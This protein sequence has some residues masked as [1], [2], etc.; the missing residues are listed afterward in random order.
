ML[1]EALIKSTCE[2]LRRKGELTRI[3]KEKRTADEIAV[4]LKGLNELLAAINP[5]ET[6]VKELKGGIDGNV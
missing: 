6:F 2:D 1:Q 3:K 4:I 5:K